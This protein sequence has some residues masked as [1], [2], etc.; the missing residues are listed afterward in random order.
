MSSMELIIQYITLDGPRNDGKL[1]RSV[2]SR[3]KAGDYIKCLPIAND[4]GEHLVFKRRKKYPYCMGTL[5]K[6]MIY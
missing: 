2:R 3:G 4:Y 6:C 5:S 1:S